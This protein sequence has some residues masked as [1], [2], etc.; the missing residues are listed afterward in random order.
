[1][2]TDGGNPK[3]GF[4]VACCKLSCV[5]SRLTAT[6]ESEWNQQHPVGSAMIDR[7]RP[8]Q[9]LIDSVWCN[10]SLLVSVKTCVGTLKNEN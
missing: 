7:L 9:P 5:A 8:V 6:D 2:H 1:M 10:R 4:N 3:D